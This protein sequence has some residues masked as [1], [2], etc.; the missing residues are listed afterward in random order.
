[1]TAQGGRFADARRAAWPPI[2]A[3]SSSLT[4][5]TTI[6]AGGEAFHDLASHRPLGDGGGEILGHFIVHVRFQEG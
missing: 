3:V 1:M 2:R 6:W 4:I 5:L